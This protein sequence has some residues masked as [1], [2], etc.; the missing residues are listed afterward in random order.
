MARTVFLHVG[1]A[2]TGTTYLQRILEAH[3]DVLRSAGLLYPGRQPGDHF[4]AAVDLRRLRSPRYDDL[5]AEGRWE[6]LAAE[7]R[8]Y[9]GDAIISHETLARC[10]R[11]AIRRAAQSL[12]TA[13]L[14][15]VLTVRDLGRQVPAVWQETLKNRAVDSYPDFLK[16]VFRHRNGKQAKFFWR[17]QDVAKV[18]RRWGREVGVANVTVVTVPPPG[19]A[20]DELWNRF[21]RAVDLPAV[22]V[23]LPPAAANVSLGAAEAELLRQVNLV[24]PTSFAWSDYA[25]VVKRQ[26]AELT[27]A[28]RATSSMSIPRR[29]HRATRARAD[30][31]VGYL[32]TSGCRVIGDLADLEPQ[33]PV[34]AVSGP[35]DLADDELLR[36]AAELIRDEILLSPTWTPATPTAVPAAR[37]LRSAARRWAA[38]AQERLRRGA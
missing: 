21:A 4:A 6:Q 2:K 10:S 26:F 36:V 14:R 5:A 12:G 20:R 31:M 32:R 13:D 8:G 33:L 9:D 38:S 19:A 3:R 7:V 35:R 37:R 29:W 17:A 28:P 18:V 24:L 1:V 27:L 22:R 16:D 30:R 25:R 11:A 23:E 15:V 34:G